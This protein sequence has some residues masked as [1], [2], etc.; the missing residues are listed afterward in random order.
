M[1]EHRLEA[2]SLPAGTVPPDVTPTLGPDATALGQIFWYTIEGRDEEG[3]P[4]GGWDLDELRS[5]QDWIVRYGLVAAEGVSEVASVGGFVKE[6]Q[7]D[8]DPDALRAYNI[9]LNDVF[10]AVKGAN[11]DVGAR[12]IDVNNVEY[13]IRGIGFI[14][15]VK[16]LE[17]SVI[18]S[19]D[20]TPIFVKDVAHVALGPALRRGVL[21]KDGAEA[22]GG[23]VV[24]RYGFNPLEAIQSVKEKIKE[25]EPLLPQ[26]T[27]PDGTVSRLEIVPF[28]DR[29]EL[30]HETLGTLSDTLALQILVTVVVILFM[31]RHF[32]NSL[33]VSATLPLAIL[34]CFIFMKTYGVDANIVS[35]VGIAIAIGVMVD[36]GVVF[37]ENIL[38]KLSESDGTK[39]RLDLIYEA[40]REVSGA[41]FTAIAT[42]IVSF[43]PV[44]SMMAAEG[45]LFRP[46][47]FTKTFA[48]VASS[49]IAFVIL[50]TVAYYILRPIPK[51]KRLLSD[52]LNWVVIAIV[53]YFLA[54]FWM[55][56]GFDKGLIRNL[57]FVGGLI[58]GLLV[59]FN[60]F[61]FA[62]PYLL[63][64]ALEWK[65][66]F[67]VL[68]VFLIC[69]GLLAWQGAS[70]L[71]GWMPR[72]VQESF[73]VS[74]INKTFPGLGR[75]F[76]P[77]L[78][79]GTFLLMPSTMPHA[80][81]SAASEI[82]EKQTEEVSKIPE[83]VTAVGKIGRV[84][85]SLDPAPLSMIETTIQYNSQFL[86]DAQGRVQLF[87]FDPSEVDYFRDVDGNPLPADDGKPYKVQGKFLRDDNNRLI[88]DS[89]G[90]PFRLWRPELDPD[91]NEERDYWKGIQSTDDI[92]DRI[93]VVSEFPGTTAS[94]KLQPIITR[95]IMLQT[96]MRAALG[97]KIRGP[98]LEAIE[99]AGIA[100][101]EELKKMPEII[102]ETVVADRIISKPYLEIQLNR[103]ALAR[104]GIKVS[105]VQQVIEVA[106]GGKRITTTV[107]GRERYP[108]RVRYLRELRD[109]IEKLNKILV[110]GSGGVQIPIE[111]LADIEYIKGPQVIKTE[112]SFLVGYL[113]FD[114]KPQYAEIDVVEA[115][116]EFLEEK[117]ASGELHLGENVSYTFAGA[118]ESQVR[119]ES[120]LRLILPI[121]LV[122]IFLLLYLQFQ[123]VLTSLIIFSSIFAAWSGGFIMIWLYGQP[124]FMD[125]AVFGVNM[126]DLF[127]MHQINLSVAIW[128]GFLALFGIATD[129][130]VLL[131]T[132]IDIGKK[133]KPFD[134]VGDVRDVVTEY[135]I[136][137]VRPALITSVTTLISLIPVLT[138]KGRGADIMIPMAIPSFGGMVIVMITIFIVPVLYS[139]KEEFHL[140][141]K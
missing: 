44:F 43:L 110:P 15:E 84:E 23:V 86:T 90:M 79:E 125:F 63:Q 115:A 104:F 95:V 20:G 71:T 3:N 97:I 122:T 131:A 51:R 87:A 24:V 32:V 96:G 5:A 68:P 65:K 136:W 83:V 81:I 12:T 47:A 22:V 61:R 67:L 141:R 120:R 62:F 21:N 59:I 107:E 42:T 82:L 48:L 55:P 60:L 75:E 33:M 105:D 139:M 27:L 94:S 126:R 37:C 9:T 133:R 91:L 40:S 58:I 8:V 100:M 72:I 26:K 35:L 101:E 103:E 70:V 130:G 1:T 66:A 29:T 138:S 54:T 128:V 45:K 56:L 132:G 113:T 114:K 124:W 116:K 119:A 25:I 34:I 134:T 28:Y 118:F 85:S 4:T 99:E 78:D 64:L 13:V 17:D 11:L 31:L 19:V 69:W 10:N 38:N 73:I 53:I 52:I 14:K 30:I 16:D 109:Q 108:V 36:A 88:S 123:S 6:Y 39:S 80:S 140:K 102:P 2:D 127:Q 41:I 129:N 89:Y 93:V 135:S 46:L 18:K 112:E 57:V 98:D 76:L 111:Q 7:V 117:I 121:T 92:W 50:P 106:I 74:S 77:P 137:R 49:F